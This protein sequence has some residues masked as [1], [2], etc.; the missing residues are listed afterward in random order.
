[1]E[2]QSILNDK[3][4]INLDRDDQEMVLRG[5]FNEYE[6]DDEFN[7]LDSA[8]QEEVYNGMITTYLGERPEDPY[9][10]KPQFELEQEGTVRPEDEVSTKTYEDTLLEEEEIA[11]TKELEIKE[12]EEAKVGEAIAKA[13]QYYQ[14][15]R[16]LTM[17]K[18]AMLKLQGREEQAGVEDTKAIDAAIEKLLRD[19]DIVEAKKNNYTGQVQVLTKEGN[20]LPLDAGFM[21]SIAA[22]KMELGHAVAQGLTAAKMTSYLSKNPWAIAGAGIYGSMTG[23]GQGA[24]EDMKTNAKFLGIEPTSEELID[25]YLKAGS[26]DLVY[27]GIISALGK[28]VKSTGGVIG[29]KAK[30]LYNIIINDDLD[31]AFDEIR[32]VSAK[33]I[34]EQDNLISMGAEM[35]GKTMPDMTT[36]EGK[37]EAIKYLALFDDSLTAYTIGGA[38]MGS[39][40]ISN[41]TNMMKSNVD[42]LKKVIKNQADAD[43]I[44]PMALKVKTD[45]GE[46]WQGM[47]DNMVRVFKDQPINFGGLHS[48]LRGVQRILSKSEGQL[49]ESTRAGL[50]TLQRSAQGLTSIDGLMEFSKTYNRVYRKLY[51]SNDLTFTEKQILKKGRSEVTKFINETIMK[52]ELLKKGEKIKLIKSHQNAREAYKKAS[53]AID[54]ELFGRLVSEGGQVRERNQLLDGLISAAKMSTVDN[55]TTNDT[56]AFMSSLTRDELQLVENS[57]I[58]RI[59]DK[60]GQSTSGIP[61]MK[62]VYQELDSIKNVLTTDSSKRLFGVIDK[63][64]DLWDNDSVLQY[65]AGAKGTFT[66]T[67]PLSSSGLSKDMT[68]AEPFK[69]AATAKLFAKA[70]MVIPAIIREFSP[71]GKMTMGIL[72]DW[73]KAGA[74]RSVWLQIDRVLT[75]ATGVQ[76]IYEGILKVDGISEQTKKNLRE[77][78]AAYKHLN[79]ALNDIPIEDRLAAQ[80]E[81]ARQRQIEIER[82][83]ETE[84]QY[85]QKQEL[86]RNIAR[87]NEIREATVNDADGNPVGSFRNNQIWMQS[88]DTTLEEIT[89]ELNRRNLEPGTRIAAN[90]GGRRR[91]PAYFTIGDD[92]KA[93][94]LVTRDQWADMQADAARIEGQQVDVNTRTGEVTAKRS[95]SD[96]IPNMENDVVESLRKSGLDV[97]TKKSGD[98]FAIRSIKDANGNELFRYNGYRDGVY[99]YMQNGEI[100][101]Y[102]LGLS[103][104]SG[105]GSKVYNALWNAAGKNGIKYRPSSQLTSSNQFRMTANYLKYASKHND[106]AEQL[107]LAS[108]MKGVPSELHGKPLTKENAYKV[109]KSYGKFIN[110]ILLAPYNTRITGETTDKELKEISRMYGGQEDR[111]FG[112]KTLK[113]IRNY[114]RGGTLAVTGAIMTALMAQKDFVAA[115]D[116]EDKGS[117]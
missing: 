62:V 14:T 54:T 9:M 69:Y 59:V 51:K 99:F 12:S 66:P 41:I 5:Y 111:K 23:S 45:A 16:I 11:K 103:E 57:I 90:I 2:I 28:L 44:V 83:K 4:F 26:D 27:T 106:S 39:E 93:S 74:T 52:N 70:Q 37:R 56:V 38:R 85:S 87:R 46:V 15:D 77:S 32:K 79:S 19:G 109:V 64:K 75:E 7:A 86:K 94:T 84:Q 89:S 1:M 78:L 80:E 115:L 100:H 96:I 92:G 60:A 116:R 49:V 24:I 18:D 71:T 36:P 42:N 81:A 98:R 20:V 58:N 25:G 30:R 34:E 107:L 91:S 43:K 117:L 73:S 110:D 17:G 101:G 8:K 105:A 22:S 13:R 63:F 88:P 114:M 6:A 102:T 35:F 10:K 31:G 21:E 65:I 3:E 33:S 53:E 112:T 113:L 82:A 104:G 29:D 97:R 95:N 61:D 50:S 40:N 76:D 47:T 55:Q 48:R 67:V 68:L 72:G 108:N